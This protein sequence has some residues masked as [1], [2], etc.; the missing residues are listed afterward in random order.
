VKE[1][2]YREGGKEGRGQWREGTSRWWEGKEWAI[3]TRWLATAGRHQVKDVKDGHSSMSRDCRPPPS[4][5]CKGWPFI[6][7]S[8]LPAATK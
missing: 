5:G 2:G 7:V 4:K 8:R 1:G 6:N 3:A